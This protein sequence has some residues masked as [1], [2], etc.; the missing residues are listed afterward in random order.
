MY[1][2]LYDPSSKPIGWFKKPNE[3]EEEKKNKKRKNKS[4]IRRP[5]GHLSK[6]YLCIWTT[7]TTDYSIYYHFIREENKERGLATNNDVGFAE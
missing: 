6:G 7:G 1:G 3:E 2:R 4:K 5:H